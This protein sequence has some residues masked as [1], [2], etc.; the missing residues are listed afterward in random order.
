M[1]SFPVRKDSFEDYMKKDTLYR[2]KL[3]TS[4]EDR[5]LLRRMVENARAGGETGIQNDIKRII[6]EETAPLW[7]G[8]YS[9]EEVAGKIQN[10]VLLYLAE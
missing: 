4:Q 2:S 3:E 9:A 5:E 1:F 10:R 6:R 8:D 7:A